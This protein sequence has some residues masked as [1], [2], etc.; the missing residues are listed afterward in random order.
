MDPPDEST[1]PNPAT[2]F[3]SNNFNAAAKR[4]D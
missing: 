2:E 4:R 1:N 3:E